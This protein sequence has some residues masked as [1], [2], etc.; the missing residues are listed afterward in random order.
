MVDRPADGRPE[1]AG[2]SDVDLIS[3]ARSGASDAFS[4]LYQRHSAAAY[5]LARQL[6]RCAGDEDDD[7][8]AEAFTRVLRRIRKGGGPRTCFRTY[9]LTTLRNVAYERYRRD[10]GKVTYVDDLGHWEDE[11]QTDDQVLAGMERSLIAKAYGQLPERW[12]TVLWYTEIESMTAAEIAPMLGMSPN[13]VSALAYRAREGLR[14]AYLQVHLAETV[15]RECQGTIGALGGWVR[16]GLG[17][18][19]RTQVEAHLDRCARCRSLVADLSDINRS[20]RAFVAPLFLGTAA[21]GYLATAGAKA[22]AAGVA[23]AAGKVALLSTVHGNAGAAGAAGGGGLVGTSTL[24]AVGATAALAA[25]VTIGLVATPHDASVAAAEPPAAVAA[26]PAPPGAIEAPPIPVTESA[27]VPVDLPEPVG[28]GEAPQPLPGAPETPASTAAEPSAAPGSP[29]TPRPTT[30]P[31]TTS[32]ATPPATTPPKPQPVDRVALTVTPKRY[33][34]HVELEVTV[35]NTGDRAGTATIAV[36]P[37]AWSIALGAGR[38]CHSSQLCS[39]ALAPGEQRTVRFRL[40]R[41]LL[42][43]G[44]TV[45]ATLGTASQTATVPLGVF[46]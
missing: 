42:P 41:T 15:A 36:A 8:V 2:P 19:E 11:E 35:R 28:G 9:L 29:N 22:S 21:A 13:S 1:G 5:N 24:A 34:L 27:P 31:A 45:R 12:R 32:P 25:V 17:V 6:T 40:I 37:P 26:A 30:P 18:R 4:V 44:T 20:L 39:V 10:G 3:A 38:D 23:G 7:L 14:Q 43:S 16:G 33:L 46:Q